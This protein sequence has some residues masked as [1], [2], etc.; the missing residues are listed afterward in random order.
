MSSS[1][2]SSH[3]TVTYTSISSDT[4]LPSWGIPLLEAYESEPEAPLSLVHAPEDPEYLTPSDDDISPTEDQPLPASPIALSPGYITDLESIEDDFEED[5][6]MDPVDY[7]ADEDEE[8][9]FKDEDEE[10]EEPFKDEDEEEEEHLAP[11]DS[12]LSVPDSVSSA[13]E[14]KPFETDESAATRPQPRSPHTVIPLSQTILRRARIFVRPHTP[15]SPSTK[16]RIVEYASAPTPSSPS[17]SPLSPLSS[18]PLSSPLP[19]I[20]SPPLLLPSPTCMDIIPEADMPIRK[21]VRF[22]AP[23]YRFEI[24]ESSAPATARQTGPALTRSVD[25]GFIYTLDVIESKSKL[26]ATKV[27]SSA[28]DTLNECD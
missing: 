17:P 4:D 15:L 12:A 24:G 25:Y 14:T 5:P 6:E 21:R 13:E 9:P 26:Q 28:F 1:S 19:L 20:P 22:T 23:S 18:P 2:S 11:S 8:E 3:A 27:V 10:E 7:A 16:A